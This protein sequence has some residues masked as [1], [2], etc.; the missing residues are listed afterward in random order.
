MSPKILL[1]QS[2][3]LRKEQLLIVFSGNEN[4]LN[5]L[6]CVS[7]S[8]CTDGIGL[9]SSKSNAIT[10]C[11]TPE[12]HDVL[13]KIKRNDL[14]MCTLAT[15]SSKLRGLFTHFWNKHAPYFVFQH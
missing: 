5:L 6:F 1:L 3:P 14:K 15:T 4:H 13:V 7:A 8:L 10:F 9:G 11:Y 12:I 2:Q